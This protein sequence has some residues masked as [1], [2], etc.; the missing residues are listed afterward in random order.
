MKQIHELI[1]INGSYAQAVVY[2]LVWTHSTV[3]IVISN[4]LQL[5]PPI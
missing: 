5:C 2:L 3:F 1:L 4:C